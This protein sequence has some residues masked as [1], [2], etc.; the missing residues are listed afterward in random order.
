MIND[1]MGKFQEAQKQMEDAKKKLNDKFVEV[2]VEGGLVKIIAN[3]NKRI[4]NI[5]ISE[6]ILKDKEALEDL[7]L[8]AVNKAIAKAEELFDSEMQ[9]VAGGMLPNLNGLF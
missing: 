1:L 9:K 2:E 3:G 6:E 8:T 4:T 7:I 5:S